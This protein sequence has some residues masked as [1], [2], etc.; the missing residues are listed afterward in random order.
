MKVN[1]AKI[2]LT[3]KA[4][5]PTAKIVEKKLPAVLGKE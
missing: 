1:E 4:E 2:I 5:N 3:G